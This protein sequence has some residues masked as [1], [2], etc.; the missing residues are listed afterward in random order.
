MIV[1]WKKKKPKTEFDVILEE[2]RKEYCEMYDGKFLIEIPVTDRNTKFKY[3]I[4]VCRFCGRVWMR[5]A[6]GETIIAN[7]WE[8]LKT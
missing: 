2:H 7:S 3:L 4:N 6:N 1:F 5:K 8:K